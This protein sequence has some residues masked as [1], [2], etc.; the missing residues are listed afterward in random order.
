MGEGNGTPVT[1]REL[2][3]AL[4]PLKSALNE[5]RGDVKALLVANAGAQAVTTWQRWF[6]GSVLFAVLGSIG[7]I[8]GL[9]VGGP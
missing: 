3:L 9:A 7:M 4:D 6:F 8:I 5:T 2:N 1:W